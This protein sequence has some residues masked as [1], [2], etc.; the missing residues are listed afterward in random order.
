MSFPYRVEPEENEHV[1]HAYFPDGHVETKAWDEAFEGPWIVKA[2]PEDDEL[3]AVS[4]KRVEALN[5]LYDVATRWRNGMMD[6]TPIATTV[7]EAKEHHHENA[8]TTAQLVAAVDA[9]EA[10]EGDGR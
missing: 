7:Q 1:F 4:K 9:M 5:R 3:V 10:L 6:R 8:T 2:L